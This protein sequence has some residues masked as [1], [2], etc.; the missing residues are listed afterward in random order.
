ME[1]CQ[2]VS[3][4]EVHSDKGNSVNWIMRENERLRLKTRTQR[5]LAFKR[6]RTW[7][8]IT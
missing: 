6:N 7:E 3:Y 5:C 8:N 4:L 2:N 1:N